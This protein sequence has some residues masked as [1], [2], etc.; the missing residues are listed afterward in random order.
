M[1]DLLKEFEN[2]IKVVKEWHNDDSG[3]PVERFVITQM[4]RDIKSYGTMERAMNR[5]IAIANRKPRPKQDIA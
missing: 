2:G 4:D 1:R 5:A 3:K